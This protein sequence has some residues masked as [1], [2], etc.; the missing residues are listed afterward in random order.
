[1]RL[2]CL[3]EARNH[4]AATRMQTAS[5]STSRARAGSSCA[6]A[7]PPAGSGSAA[8]SL[9]ASSTPRGTCSSANL[10]AKMP[11]LL[12]APGKWTTRH[13]VMQ[14]DSGQFP[15]VCKAGKA[16]A[17]RSAGCIMRSNM[18]A[19]SFV[20]RC[21]AGLT[22][23]LQQNGR[24]RHRE[25]GRRC[26]SHAPVI[27]A[28]LQ[29]A[30]GVVPSPIQRVRAAANLRIQVFRNSACHCRSSPTLVNGK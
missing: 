24:C 12:S 3:R 11:L 28:A 26:C 10:A 16:R 20:V 13:G 5:C 30:A 4:A 2:L 23:H 7:T 6:A 18:E 27:G 17:P 1:M 22:T 29:A 21:L 14:P 25:S 9:L 15:D 8:L 19:R